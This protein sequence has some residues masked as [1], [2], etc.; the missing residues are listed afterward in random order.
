MGTDSVDRS[1]ESGMWKGFAGEFYIGISSG[2]G[3]CTG[4]FVWGE[5]LGEGLGK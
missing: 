2:D 4:N 3:D 1:D 5:V